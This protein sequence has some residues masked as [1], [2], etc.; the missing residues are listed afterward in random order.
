MSP[1]PPE[2]T[3]AAEAQAAA[4]RFQDDFARVRAQIARVIVGHEGVVEGGRTTRWAT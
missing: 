1:G 2:V 4:E 3:S